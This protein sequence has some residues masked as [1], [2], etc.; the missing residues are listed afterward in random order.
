MV[1]QSPAGGSEANLGS[2]VTI[3]VSTGKVPRSAVPD[4]VG[5]TES[6]AVKALRQAGFVTAVGYEPTKRQNLHGVVGAQSPGAGTR[7]KEGATVS[8]T[9]YEYRE[10]KPKPNKPGKPSPDPAP[11]EFGFERP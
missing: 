10:P 3:E 2:S 8:I 5:M 6:Q 9:V 7:A 4:V 11:V 1:A